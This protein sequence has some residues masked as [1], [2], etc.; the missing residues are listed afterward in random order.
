M[1]ATHSCKVL[2]ARAI[3][4]RLHIFFH[5]LAILA[6]FYYRFT[7]L[8]TT[9]SSLARLTWALLVIAELILT[10]IWGF[11]QGFRWRSVL[12][13]VSGW[14]SIKPHQLPGLDVFIVTA[15]PTKEPVLEVMNSVI[16]AMALDYPPDKLAVYLSDDG[17]S[18]LTK[19]AIREAFQVAKLWI[20][21][22]NKYGI[23]TRIPEFF[24]SPSCD[25]E[26]LDWDHDYKAQEL[27]IKSKY[28]ALKKNIEKGSGDT[29]KCRMVHDRAPYVEIINDNKQDGESEAKLP[30]LVYVAREKRPN[31]PHRFKAGALNAL[32]RV[33]SLMSNGSY[34]LI[35]DCDMYCN[36]PTSAR[37]SMCFHLDP[38]MSP[39][40]A[41]VLYPQIFYNASKSNDIYD[42]QARSA[43]KT[44]WQA[45]DGLRGPVM[46]GTGYY[47]KRKALFGRPNRE[48][49][50][51]TSQPEKA[52]G[53][54]TKFI[55]SLHHNSKQNIE[56]KQ[57]NK[58]ELLEEARRLATCTYEANTLWGDKVGFSYECLLES[59]FTG[60]L[61]HCRGWKSV[62]L[63]PTRPCFLGVT[64]IDMKDTMVQ[65]VKWTSGLLGVGISKYSPITYA[66]SRMSI[67][68]SMCYAYLTLS[69]LFGFPF[70]IYGI[71][72]PVCSLKGIPVF[73]KINDPWIAPF[74]V[75]FVSSLVQ[76]LYEVLSGGDSVRTWW[77]EVRIW[78]IKGVGAC[79]FGSIEAIMKK[80]GKQ[81]T[82]FRL[83]NKVVEKEKLDNYEK[84]KFD[85]QGA[86]MFMVPVDILATLNLLGFIGC[87]YRVIIYHNYQELFAQLFLSFFLLVLSRSIIERIAKKVLFF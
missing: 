86:D 52:F 70:V 36:D 5:A 68:Q 3:L 1:V 11:A 47:L 56:L 38:N 63:N 6:L 37:Q 35:L 85:F 31:H 7:S 12:R 76:H 44:K 84:G 65:L 45:M 24:F 13:D 72:V 20:P 17:G 16:S 2:T 49:E 26:R 43:T 21:F 75:V 78:F 74:V 18:P 32:L 55:D 4:S 58:D 83:T 41:F 40:L 59:T 42:G 33:S 71:V 30:L 22:C 60:Y 81:K 62:Y 23:K 87:L 79:L 53:S 34:I 39:S 48:D 82:T 73:P 29:S 25:R 50:F 46:T 19:E 51:L 9:T 27:L 77:N 69:G 15:D 57:M 28:E 54:S 10:F 8:F 14:E 67:L 64:T 61:L 80:M 66:M